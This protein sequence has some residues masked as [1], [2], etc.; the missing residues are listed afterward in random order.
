MFHLADRFRPV[1]SWLLILALGAL[2]LLLIS[3]RI[4][5]VAS[6]L[7][8]H[9]TNGRLF[10]ESGL[11]PTT[12]TYS[13]TYPDFPFMNHHWCS[14]VVFEW[15]RRM[16]G[17]TG[18]SIAALSLTALTYLL[19]VKE[20]WREGRFTWAVLAT[21]LLLPTLTSRAEVR[22]ELFSYLWSAIFLWILLGVRRGSLRPAFLLILPLIELLWVNMHIYFFLGSVFIGSFLIDAIVHGRRRIALQLGGI[23]FLSLATSILNPNGLSGALYPLFIFQDFAYT[24][25]ENLTPWTVMQR[26]RKYPPAFYFVAA[27]IVIVLSWLWNLWYHWQRRTVPDIAFLLV[28]LFTSAIAWMAIR[29]FRIFSLIHLIVLAKN[30]RT[31]SLPNR[32]ERHGIWLLPTGVVFSLMLMAALQ[33]SYWQY[34]LKL[35][36]LGLTAGVADSLAFFEEQ[37]LHGPIL[38]NYD[39]G[40]FLTYGLFPGEKVFVDNRP[41]AYPGDFFRETVLPMQTNENI[42]QSADAH[43]RFNVIYYYVQDAT[44]AGREFLVRRA[45]D[46]NWAT[47]F[48]DSHAI[49]LLRRT[50]ENTAVIDRHEI[51]PRTRS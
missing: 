47:V 13:Y 18:L 4:L 3:T 2:L 31:I 43:Y 23:L 42:W 37:N 11:I 22:P 41:E 15:I 51:K 24:V 48:V 34:R 33:W 36:G 17:F 46:P 39:I 14:G 25:T 38:N 16:S 30:L 50:E 21:V 5:L 40:G 10:L 28:S 26:K 20:A 32:W 1:L 44:R 8:R 49:I 12:N 7:G 29:N 35:T 45:L 27:F 9:L 6:D 19:Y